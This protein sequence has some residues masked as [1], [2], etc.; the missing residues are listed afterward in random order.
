MIGMVTASE[1]RSEGGSYRGV[2]FLH[3]PKTAGSSLTDAF[4]F[5]FP[6]FVRDGHLPG[7]PWRGILEGSEPFFVSGHFP[8][9]TIADVIERSEVFSFTVLRDPW[10]QVVS[11]IR[12]V[13]AYGDPEREEKLSEIDPSIA[14]MA[15]KLWPIS[16]DDVGGLQTIIQAS[17]G[18]P[19]R[20][21]Q[22]L[23]L[24]QS[25]DLSSPECAVAEAMENLARFDLF[26]VLEDL[27]EGV[28]LMDEKFGPLEPVKRSNRALLEERPN[29]ND[30]AV[31]DFYGDLIALDLELYD[32]AKAA[33]RV[34]F[35]EIL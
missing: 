30:R 15:K 10:E 27:A 33:S 2:L 31:R 18:S 35:Q 7:S 5:S 13:K 1:H 28:R 29:F 9:A 32:Q 16:L 21:L 12:W 22:T 34:F 26:F 20:N 8:F 11:H 6:H 4:C 3:I 19:F 24:R 14:E 17:G 23:F 25:R